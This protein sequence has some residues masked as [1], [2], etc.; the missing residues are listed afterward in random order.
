MNISYPMVHVL[1][2]LQTW[3]EGGWNIDTVC[4]P[5]ALLFT[6]GTSHL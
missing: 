3:I 4:R 6:G 5:G 2:D 1:T